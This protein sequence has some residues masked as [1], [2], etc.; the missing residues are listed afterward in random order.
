EPIVISTSITTQ[1]VKEL[2]ELLQ[3]AS[4]SPYSIASDWIYTDAETEN[5]LPGFTVQVRL[6]SKVN[7]AVIKEFAPDRCF[8][9]KKLAKEVSAGVALEYLKE[10]PDE[11]A[12][13]PKA[14]SS[15]A[16]S[17]R[18]DD[19]QESVN[20]VGM[21]QDFCQQRGALP[22]YTFF[23]PSKAHQQFSCEITGVPSVQTKVFG[24][25]AM[26]YR[27]KKIAK[28]QAAKAAMLYLNENPQPIPPKSPRGRAGSNRSGQ[29]AGKAPP[30]SIIK[31]P[32]TI[33]VVEKV[34]RICPQLGLSLPDYAF[35]QD[36]NAPSLFD[37]SAIVRRGGDKKDA[38]FGRLRGKLGKK[39]AK[40]HMAAAIF[41]WLHTEA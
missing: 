32:A 40:E 21:L 3:S 38:R 17:M 9:T 4:Y 6:K 8:P 36:P 20:W 18:S 14:E 37:V 27:N 30:G 1:Y 7:D 23:Q 39:N 5:G 28:V 19:P 24:S 15:D 22:L 10:L 16:G 11:V 31:V 33:G 12:Q 2:H 34:S 29:S 26:Y 35:Y 25:K 41:R 13:L